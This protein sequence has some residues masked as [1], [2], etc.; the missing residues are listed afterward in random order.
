[1]AMKIT[2]HDFHVEYDSLCRYVNKYETMKHCHFKAKR[3]P[4]LNSN[5]GNIPFF[6]LSSSSSPTMLCI[7]IVA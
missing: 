6:L 7:S 2:F 3:D 1:M 4:N 5:M